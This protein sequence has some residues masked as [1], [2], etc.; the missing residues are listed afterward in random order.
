MTESGFRRRIEGVETLGHRQAPSTPQSSPQILNEPQCRASYEGNIATDQHD[1]DRYHPESEHR[2]ETKYT[3]DNEEDA[4]GNSDPDRLAPD[5]PEIPAD[6]VS[7]NS[8]CPLSSAALTHERVSA[9]RWRSGNSNSCSVVY[10]IHE[11]F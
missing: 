6:R 7:M 8:G 5:E 2:K 1:S 3:R 4:D 9:A 10:R 11:P